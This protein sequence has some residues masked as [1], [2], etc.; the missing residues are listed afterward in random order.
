MRFCKRCIEPDTR[1]G[2]EFDDEGICMPCRY[3][4]N[5][6]VVD[7]D[8]RRAELQELADWAKGATSSSY[9]C[10]V[11]VSG[12]KDSTRQALYVRDELGLQP[13]LVTCAYP[14]EEQSERGAHNMANLVELGFDA[15]Y[16]SPA[17]DLWR[18]DGPRG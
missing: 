2:A 13:L 8:A 17:P 7:W 11:P 18:R 12:G 5:A 4:E 6:P 10:I 3:T 14:P 15:H 16:I 9:D 1:P